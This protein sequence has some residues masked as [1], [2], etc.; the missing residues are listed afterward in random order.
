MSALLGVVVRHE[1]RLRLRFDTELA[2]AAFRRVSFYR[3]TNGDG[4][5]ASPDVVGVL[6][7]GA[8]LHQVEL[9]LGSD[10]V[11]GALYEVAVDAVPASDASTATGTMA[12]RPAEPTRASSAV[13]AEDDAGVLLYGVDLLHDGGDYVEAEDGDLAT[14]D[15]EANLDSAL[16][17]RMSSD[18][19]L[20][21]A[22]YGAA[23]RRYVDGSPGALP[24]LRGAL[25]AQA[26]ADDRVSAADAVL[27]ADGTF[28]VT[29]T[30]AGSRAP[31]AF[32]IPIR[33]S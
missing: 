25:V 22:R 14:I 8:D 13:A 31:R 9:A 26:L 29:V 11:G 10:L 12:L 32:R 2:P 18:G 1:R 20:W 21:D 15:G 17:R 3:V 6:V 28:E 19:L 23:P 27:E 24:T 30:P 16:L 7:V 33:T 4:R 5:G